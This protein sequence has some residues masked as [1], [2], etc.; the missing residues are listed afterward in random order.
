MLLA[1]VTRPN[2]RG[3]STIGGK[4]STVCTI[5]R[6]SE[7][8]TT[9]ASSDVDVPTRTRG[10]KGSRTGASKAWRRALS[11]LAAQPPAWAC[12]VSRIF[13]VSCGMASSEGQ[14]ERGGDVLVVRREERTHVEVNRPVLD[15]AEHGD[16]RGAQPPGQL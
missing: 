13:L 7:T 9:P 12:W 15:R 1:A 6:S 8:R 3:S 10:S 2:Q 14:G 5:A 4:K 11:T 16:R